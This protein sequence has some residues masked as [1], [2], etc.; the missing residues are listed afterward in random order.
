VTSPLSY[1]LRNG[2]ITFYLAFL[3]LWFKGT[4]HFFKNIPIPPSIPLALLAALTGLRFLLRYRTKK[5]TFRLGRPRSWAVPATLVLSAIAI[6]VPFFFRL[7]GLFHGDDAIALL[8]SKHIAEGNLPP[9]YFY[10]QDYLGT[11]PHHLYALIFQFTG[12]SLLALA[13]VYMIFYLGFILVQYYLFKEIG[14]SPKISALLALFY[15]LPIGELL[16]ASF[17]F[18]VNISIY[19]FLGSLGLYLSLLV[20]K[21]GRADLLPAI[22]LILGLAFWTHPIVLVYALCSACL[23][24]WR[25]RIQIKRYLTLAGYFLVGAFP[26]VLSEINN[27]F[28]TIRFLFAG[29]A[30]YRPWGEKIRVVFQQIQHL[31]TPQINLW[32]WLLLA[33]LALGILAIL[34]SCLK[35]KKWHPEVIFV[36]FFLLCP[37]IYLFSKFTA[38]WWTGTRYVYPLYFAIPYLLFSF[39]RYLPSSFRPATLAI[40]LGLITIFP[41]AR[42]TLLNYQEIKQSQ[43]NVHKILATAY[44]T[45]KKYWAGEFW[46]VMFLTGLSKEKIVGWCYNHE[47]YWP[48]RLQYF[49]NGV[50]NNFIFLKNIRGAHDLK[51]KEFGELYYDHLARTYEEAERF[52]R[53][54]TVLH[55]PAKTLRIKNCLFIYDISADVFPQSIASPLPGPIPEAIL[56]AVQES[57]EF[58]RLTFTLNPIAQNEGFRLAAEI[59]G[60]S[61]AERDLGPGQENI[62]ILLPFPSK[63]SIFIQYHLNYAGM[64]IPFS[65]KKYAYSAIWPRPATS[66][67]QLIRLAGFGPEVNLTGK[68]MTIGTRKTKFKIEGPVRQK[69]RLIF[70]IF[71]PFQFSHPYWYGAY[72]QRLDIL[73]NN[74]FLRSEYLQDGFNRI[75]LDLDHPLFRNGSNIILFVA[76]Y[77]LPFEF[78]PLWKTSYLLEK[79]ELL[80]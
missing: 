64:Q 1:W 31:L 34:A 61:S 62:Q 46:Q 15:C 5:L 29:Q 56:S 42:E 35:N 76:K 22:G 14:A 24:A 23:I 41:N 13:I 6:R 63:A 36:I 8:I 77:Q 73:V 71:S 20:H 43:E 58:I 26:T 10:G 3:C 28:K 70:Q 80:H 25:Y 19:F 74:Q 4:I 9:I 59:P 79:T 47:D 60:Y 75:V 50:N 65:R 69:S 54:L 37:V 49:N 27:S 39:I 66:P 17:S 18:G 78:A 12:A 57:E 55:I 38:I 16:G 7:P 33:L 68:Q 72:E 21:H 2:Q 51:L 45:G 67:S 32:N 44:Q 40:L 11:L 30:E 48:Y 53:L 52:I